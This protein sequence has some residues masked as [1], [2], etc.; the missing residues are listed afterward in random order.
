[1]KQKKR[2]YLLQKVCA[3]VF[4]ILLCLGNGRETIAAEDDSQLGNQRLGNGVITEE[5]IEA[6]ETKK[7]GTYALE[8]LEEYFY[9]ETVDEY[10]EKLQ[11]WKLENIEARFPGMVHRF[12]EEGYFLY[13]VCEVEEGGRYF[14]MQLMGRLEMEGRELIGGPE[15]EYI[16]RIHPNL[17]M[18]D[19]G[20]IGIYLTKLNSEEDF[21]S[22]IPGWS[23]AREVKEIDPYAE[24]RMG[25]SSGIQIY[26]YSVLND[27]RILEFQMYHYPEKQREGMERSAW[28]QII[29]V[30]RTIERSEISFSTT[31]GIIRKRDLEPFLSEEG[32]NADFSYKP[33]E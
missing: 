4:L 29:D 11:N 20:R 17:G 26:M 18:W 15:Y 13:S 25:Y 19:G 12:D 1:M 16:A 10:A 22:I 9:Y 21:D 31:V 5:L 28:D 24:I 27:G 30:K 8:E 2:S 32:K 6:Q 23:T 14:A 33:V 7:M 3:A